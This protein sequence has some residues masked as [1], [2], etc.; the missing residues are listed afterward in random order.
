MASQDQ[1]D[2]L[3]RRLAADLARKHPDADPALAEA[4]AAVPRH[5]FLPRLLGVTG[6][7]RGSMAAAESRM[8]TSRAE[9]IYSDHALPLRPGEPVA[10]STSSAPGIMWTMLQM[11]R[12][13]PG[14]RILEVGCG[15]GYNAA[16][17]G[18]LVGRR[19]RVESVEIAPDVAA[20]AD[21]C[22]EDLGID[23]V[24]VTC[25]DGTL[26]KPGQEPFDR[27][28]VTASPADI[29]PA[30]L[31]QLAE[32][33]RLV[34][35]LETAMGQRLAEFQKAHGRL[36]GSF[37]TWVAFVPMLGESTQYPLMEAASRAIRAQWAELRAQPMRRIT[38]ANTL[39][40]HTERGMGFA[41]FLEIRHGRRAA[42]VEPRQR[43]RG[44]VLFQ[45]AEG[46]GLARVGSTWAAD[47]IELTAVG[48]E[49]IDAELARHAHEFAEL[50]RSI[51]SRLPVMA[52]PIASEE[53]PPPWGVGRR[54]FF[55][56]WVELG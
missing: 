20:D 24:G 8:S 55:E 44:E 26:G 53:H 46:D 35:V 29:H 11:L 5:R 31:D 23:N 40:R 2:E 18:C 47:P 50:H 12:P 49:T 43:H 15:S 33:G 52:R 25:G 17:M 48:A 51:E 21:A 30:W 41:V 19:G 13:R 38:L 56:Y 32:G 28:I 9:E 14:D 22:I 4:F 7:P 39:P 1:L 54:E 42:P 10:R 34:T 45:S 3:R 16:I 36:R 37:G 27:V 6:D